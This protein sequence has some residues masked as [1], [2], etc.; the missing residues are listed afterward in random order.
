MF[1]CLWQP[2]VYTSPNRYQE[3]LSKWSL[4]EVYM[5][6]PL[7]FEKGIIDQVYK[8][9]LYGL[10]RSLRAWFDKFFSVIYDLN[11][12]VRYHDYALFLQSFSLGFIVLLLYIDDI[13][14]TTDD[15]VSIQ[16]L[17]NQLQT[18]F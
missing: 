14:L 16:L 17:K 12:R 11:F 6:L 15:T 8:L 3:C 4:K 10:K 9:S 2:R 18:H 13:I 7:G 5:N 1:Y